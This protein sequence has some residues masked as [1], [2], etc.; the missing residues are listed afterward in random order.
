MEVDVME[1]D[2]LVLGTDGL[3]DNLNDMEISQV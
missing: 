2:W 1:G 3:W